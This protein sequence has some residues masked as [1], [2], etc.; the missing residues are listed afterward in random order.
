MLSTFFKQ[1]NRPSIYPHP[2]TDHPLEATWCL[3]A[4]EQEGYHHLKNTGFW[5]KAMKQEI[6]LLKKDLQNGITEQYIPLFNEFLLNNDTLQV[7][8]NG[9]LIFSSSKDRLLALVQ[10]LDEA[11]RKRLPVVIFDKITGNAA[12]LLSVKANAQAV[13]SP[14]CSR[15]AIRTLDKYGIEY[16]FRKIVP[17]I[18][19]E[20]S[21]DMCPMEKLSIY[22]SPEEFYATV[23]QLIE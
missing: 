16:H 1:L 6:Y 23:K 12:A 14:I 20:D 8:H 18:Q 17:F 19:R 13:Y 4:R 11:S 10:Y 21:D 2:V 15:L 9:D 7:Y 5:S 3:T 22:E